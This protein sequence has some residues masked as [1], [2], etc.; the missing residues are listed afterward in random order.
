MTLAP[1]WE[2]RHLAERHL[3]LRKGLSRGGGMTDNGS[4]LRTFLAEL[5]R[6]R[7]FRVAV[8]Y[9]VASFA[10]L[11]V[12]DIAFPALRLPDW[13]MTLVVAITLLGFPIAMVLAWAFDITPHG[14]VR[15][16]SAQD[17]TF[18]HRRPARAPALI[19]VGLVLVVTVASGWYLLPK[20][21]GWWTIDRTS[22]AG[23]DNR[24]RLA[25]LPFVNLGAPGDAYFADGITEEITARLA[26]IQGLGVIAR[27][28]SVQYR[29]TDKTVRE[30]GQELGVDYVLEGTV[31]WENVSDGPSRV[32]VTPQLI[33]VADDTHV[34]A[35]IYEEPIAS[36]FEVQSE[37]AERVVEALGVTLVERERVALKAGPTSNVEAYSYYLLGEKYLQSSTRA[38]FQEALA[39]FES[40]LELDPEF[41]LARQRLAETH[42]NLYWGSFR[43]LFG[44]RDEDYQRTLARL[45]LSSF[46][47]D[48]GSY[49]LARALVLSR[50]ATGEAG[51]Y[52]DSAQAFLEPK[53]A[54]RPADPYLHAQ[55]GLAYA[56]L[57]RA[58]DAV[59]QGRRAVELLPLSEDT[60]AGA[61]LVDNLAHIYV[62]I[63]DYDAAVAQLKVLLSVDSP[64][65]VPWLMADP[66]WDPLRDHPGFMNLLEGTE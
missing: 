33:R 23:E 54:R 50:A 29:D 41:R 2:R 45:S 48:T 44:V 32:R 60:Y 62:M 56:G 65:S 22:E 30:I 21:P 11:Q 3:K 12:A 18:P 42:A 61:A 34:W 64:V 24:E 52:Y 8:V 59:Q 46:G 39:M 20:L 26:S 58:D 55:L 7:V 4:K 35:H 43:T 6:R 13:T 66:T 1:S 17:E 37:I 40:A 25:V 10:I 49:Y 51:T 9:A 27:T 47:P 15:T 5:Q 36:V 19:A 63:G 57:G 14:V 38:G 31:R 28:T 53:A 16:A